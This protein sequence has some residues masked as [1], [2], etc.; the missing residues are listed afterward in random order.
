M[1][2]LNDH[3]PEEEMAKFIVR[4]ESCYVGADAEEEFEIPDERLEG[5]TAKQRHDLAID[6]AQD[7]VN[8]YFSW[9]V[10]ELS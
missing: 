10:E 8:N 4:I 9:G 6:W 7:I 3:Q 1:V 2:G 5:L